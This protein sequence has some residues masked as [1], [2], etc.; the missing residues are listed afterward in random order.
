MRTKPELPPN[1]G[2]WLAS[3]SRANSDLYSVEYL[4][5]LS[6]GEF[7]TLS[8]AYEYFT[9]HRDEPELKPLFEAYKA[10]RKALKTA[11][12]SATLGPLPREFVEN[13]L[14]TFLLVWRKAL[15]NLAHAISSSF[16]KDSCRFKAYNANRRLAFDTYFGYR[17]VES[18]RNLTQHRETPPIEQALE[19]HPYICEKCCQEHKD[20]PDL[21]VTLSCAWLKNGCSATLKRELDTLNRDTIDVVEVVDQ[22]M[23]GFE[24]I[25]YAVLLSTHYGPAH[26]AALVS[27]FDE[28]HPYY[29]VLVDYTGPTRTASRALVF[30]HYTP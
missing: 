26:R 6:K 10:W 15:D 18:M 24:D 23:Q 16:G 2:W 3:S 22:S 5:P 19:H 28:T 29:P 14:V 20:T 27:V 12:R 1:E 8:A 13:A 11:P 30:A 21:L 17:V 4:H 7:D 25:L 9:H